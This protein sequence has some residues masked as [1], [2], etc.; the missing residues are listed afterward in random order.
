M[1][2]MYITWDEGRQEYVCP[3]CPEGFSATTHTDADLLMNALEL[4]VTNDHPEVIS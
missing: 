4:H 1:N 2:N 3:L